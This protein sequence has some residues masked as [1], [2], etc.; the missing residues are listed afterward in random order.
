MQQIEATRGEVVRVFS[1]DATDRVLVVKAP[2]GIK[3]EFPPGRSNR[4]WVPQIGT[5]TYDWG[6]GLDGA[7]EVVN[8]FVPNVSSN[9]VALPAMIASTRP[10]R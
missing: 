7:I 4:V 6:D 5:W 8:E 3:V 1:P 9:P 2:S 10:R